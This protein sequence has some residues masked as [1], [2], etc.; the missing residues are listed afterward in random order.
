MGARES[1]QH[2]PLKTANL[3]RMKNIN[4]RFLIPV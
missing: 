4:Y 3:E 2:N 1:K